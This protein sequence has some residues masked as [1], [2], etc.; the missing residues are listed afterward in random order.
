MALISRITR[1]SSYTLYSGTLSSSCSVYNVL[2]IP[3][4]E[5]KLFMTAPKFPNLFLENL[6]CRRYSS[7]SNKGFHKNTS[8]QTEFVQAVPKKDLSQRER[9][10]QAVKEYGTTLIVF[11]VG[12]SLM[13]LG[14]SYLAVSNG[15]DPVKIFTFLGFSESVISS[16]VAVEGS[17]FVIAYGVH[18]VFAPVRIG[19][20]LSCVP[21][22]VRYL[23]KIKWLKPPVKKI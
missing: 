21:F 22:I 19:I 12:I 23:R 11:H 15:V 17:T 5:Y 8:E 20:T 2:N 10:K 14:L 4:C 3:C 7:Q 16:K 9:L 13:S 18:K 6:S 1:L